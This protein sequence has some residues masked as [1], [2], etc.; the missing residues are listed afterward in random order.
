M[1][2]TQLQ[3]EAFDFFQTIPCSF[4][5]EA[6]KDSRINS[7][8]EAV[9]EVVNNIHLRVKALLQVSSSVCYL[10]KFR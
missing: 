7:G 5:F 10:E 3:N 4:R 6:V 2:G 8:S 1:S 9:D